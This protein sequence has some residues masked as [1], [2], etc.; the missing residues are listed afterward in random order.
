MLDLQAERLRHGFEDVL[1][2]TIETEISS[3]EMT[4]M[5][6]KDTTKD[7]GELPGIYPREFEYLASSIFVEL[8]TP[9]VIL[10]TYYS[11]IAYVL[12]RCMHIVEGTRFTGKIWDAKYFSHGSKKRWSSILL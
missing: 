6:M 8:N 3:K 1:G 11:V 10:Y 12:I 5:L 7:E 2:K 9:S 4:E